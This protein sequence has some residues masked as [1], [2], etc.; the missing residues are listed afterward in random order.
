MPPVSPL[1]AFQAH[2]NQ[3]VMAAC[4]PSAAGPDFCMYNAKSL[5]H[6][7]PHSNRVS[8]QQQGLCFS[9]DAV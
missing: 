6:C 7:N 2:Q 4:L 3:E 1:L 5:R 9:A 8:R